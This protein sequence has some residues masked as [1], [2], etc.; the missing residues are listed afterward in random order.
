VTS[1]RVSVQNVE[2][3]PGEECGLAGLAGLGLVVDKIVS[4]F[5]SRREWHTVGREELMSG[6]NGLS[7]S[8]SLAFLDSSACIFHLPGCMG[9][10]SHARLGKTYLSS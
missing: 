6:P 9:G 7:W 2:V 5:R 10:A 3:S 4:G 8:G 1:W